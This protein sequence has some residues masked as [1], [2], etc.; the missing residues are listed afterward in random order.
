MASNALDAGGRSIFGFATDVI[1]VSVL[2]A[3]TAQMGLL[4]AAGMVAFLFLAA[5]VGVLVDRASSRSTL[6]ISSLAKAT[7][8]G[9]AA[10]LLLSATMTFGMLLVI[11]VT[12]G[13]FS[14]ITE[15]SQVAAVPRVEKKTRIAALA[16]RSRRG[17]TGSAS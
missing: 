9:L 7:L 16:V 11:V 15:T 14:L 10:A 13:V 8:A 17:T 6:V 3:S 4:N 2:G 5:P 12:F 1:A